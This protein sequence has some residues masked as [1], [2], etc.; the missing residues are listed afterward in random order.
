MVFVQNSLFLSAVD[1]I[2][3]HLIIGTFTIVTCVVIFIYM[4]LHAIKAY[5]N[6][7][8]YNFVFNVVKWNS[9]F[10]FSCVYIYTLFIS[11]ST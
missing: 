9:F 4:Y 5:M 3:L 6:D 10:L 11:R 2:E 8:E 7:I 1:L